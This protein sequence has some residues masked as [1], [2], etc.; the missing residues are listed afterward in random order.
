M[1]LSL[2]DETLLFLYSCLLGVAFGVIFDL[3]RAFRSIVASNKI[4]VFIQDVLLF[5]I[6]SF[7]S[8]C[9]MIASTDGELRIFVLVGE[10]AGF[11]IYICTVSKPVMKLLKVVAKLIKKILIIIYKVFLRPFIYIFK[12]IFKGLK[13]IYQK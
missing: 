11:I 7:L 13:A 9:F 10:A 12:K 2:A 5:L 1:G 3:F 8:F 4:N 6:Y